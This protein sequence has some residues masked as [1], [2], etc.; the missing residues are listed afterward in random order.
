[1]IGMRRAAV[2]LGLGVNA[3][4]NEEQLEYRLTKDSR[5]ELLPNVSSSVIGEWKVHFR[6]WVI[7]CAFR[8]LVEHLCLL[9]DRI[10]YCVLKIPSVELAEKKTF[11]DFERFGL[12]KKLEFL[13][14]GFGIKSNFN[15]PLATL[16]PVRTCFVHRLGRVGNKDLKGGE[17]KLEW[18]ALRLFI[19][20]PSGELEFPLDP[21]DSKPIELPEG[22]SLMAQ[23]LAARA[24]S[25]SHGDS[26]ELSA[27]D[28]TEILFFA[29]ICTKQL[30][31][32]AGEF[33]K[34]KDV[35]I[36]DPNAGPRS[37]GEE[38]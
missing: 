6:S 24:R 4:D 5:I 28:L 32:S 21:R 13:S 23:P 19:V 33:L 34:S 25:Y 11:E 14:R 9:L 37:E 20:T 8:E 31:V 27:H 7:G 22:G 38:E 16:Y 26:I 17:L 2:F 1:M 15:S 36:I 3:A 18:A 12:D 30:L 10:Y 35:Q 29:Q